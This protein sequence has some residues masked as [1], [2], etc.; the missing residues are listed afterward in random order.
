MT[1]RYNLQK[2][3]A[4]ATATSLNGSNSRQPIRCT[5]SLQNPHGLSGSSSTCAILPLGLPPLAPITHSSHHTMEGPNQPHSAEDQ[6][7]EAA[8][9]AS[10]AQK[11]ADDLKARALAAED[12][13]TR[14]RLLAESR[15]KEVE[16]RKHSRRAHRLA[17]GAW[18][19]GA[20]GA[21]VGAVVGVGL[22]TVV[23][24]LVGAIATVPTT[25]LG[26]LVGVPVGWIHGPW[27]GRE[28]RKEDKDPEGVGA[29]YE[30]EEGEAREV[31]QSKG[32]DE[33][34]D[35][36]EMMDE[37]THRAIL[38]AVEAADKLE[39]QTHENAQ[40][41]VISNI[42]EPQSQLR[43]DEDGGQHRN[44]SPAREIAVEE[45]D[46]QEAAHAKNRAPAQVEEPHLK[47]GQEGEQHSDVQPKTKAMEED[48]D[49]R[50]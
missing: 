48:G 34:A 46:E 20:R 32:I 29:E 39:H 1:S 33:A 6:V 16:A 30:A 19:G 18:Q 8:R 14:A 25:G 21:G 36:D 3:T 26:F 41:P 31:G 45:S 43:Q 44:G 10:Q 49:S 22:G 50:T 38:E 9:A 23:G 37:E 27:V 17:S 28:R 42:E 40:E 2:T 11:L 15:A 12:S 35:S 24:T 5:Q 4:F 7:A 13:E 47:H